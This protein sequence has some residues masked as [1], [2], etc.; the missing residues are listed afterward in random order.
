[1]RAPP[2]PALALALA[3]VAAPGQAAAQ[4][5]LQVVTTSTDLKALVEAV[6]GERV[7][8]ESLAAPNQDPHSI[9]VKPAQVA[10]LRRAALVVRVGLDHEPWFSR[11]KASAPIVDASRGVRLLQTETPRLRAERRAHV[12]ALGNTHY[13]LDP[14]N[15]R[16]ITASILEALAK[17]SP[18]DRQ[19]FEANRNDSLKKLDSGIERWTAALAPYR[20]SK[21]VVIHDSWIYFADRFGLSIV[22]AAEPHPGVPPS[23]AELAALFKR[24]REAGVKVVIADPHSSPSLVRQ[25]SERGGAKAVTLLPSVGGEPA[26]NDYVSL[27]DLNVKRLASAL[28]Q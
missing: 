16:P 4:E 13:W 18:A 28:L 21:V 22:A 5:K 8:V 27:F 12:H 3:L 15:A 1:M 25:I 9:E 20:G 7:E 10:R 26:A 24:M 11:L 17:L 6:G 23:P 19:R 2:A 14:D